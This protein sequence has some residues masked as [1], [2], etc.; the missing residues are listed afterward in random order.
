[1]ARATTITIQNLSFSNVDDRDI[2]GLINKIRLGIEYSLF[3]NLVS[4]SPFS[5][6]EWSHFLHLSE[7]TMQRYKRE[8][9]TFDAVSSEKIVE[10]AL[11]YKAWGWQFSVIRPISTP[12]SKPKMWP[13]AVMR[14]RISWTTPSA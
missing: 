10:I 14:P 12:G 1:M 8:K 7:R 2:L 6:T 4:K 11:L 9:K 5:L 3:A 13:W